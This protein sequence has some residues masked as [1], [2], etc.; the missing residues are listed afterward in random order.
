MVVAV[1]PDRLPELA[2]RCEYYGVEL[3]DIGHFTGDGVLVVRSGGAA[4]LELGTDVPAR[5][6][7]AA[8]DDGD[9]AG[10]RP[11]A[12]RHARLVDD[13]AAHAA[14]AARPPQ[15]RLQGEH[16]PSLRPRDPRCRPSCARWSAASAT[17]PPTASCS[18]SRRATDGIAIGIGVNPWYG[19][20]DPERMAYAAV[21]EA[22]RNVV[23][24]GADPD[25]VALARQLLVGRPAA[26][27]RRWASWS[28]PSTA[29][30]PPP[31]AYRAPFVSGQG[32]AQQRVH[33]RRR[34][35]PRGAADAGD[36]RRRPRARRRSLRHAG[37]A[38]GGRRRAAARRRRDPSSPGSHLDLVHGAPADARRRAR[39]RS[40]RARALPPP[41]PGDP[42]RSRAGLPRRQRGWVGGGA[43]GD[44]HRRPARHHRHRASRTT[45]S[46]RRCSPSRRV[47]PGRRGRAAS[48]STDFREILGIDT[49]S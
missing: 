16:D 8:P 43:G 36:H 4:V 47:A 41:A 39:A 7:P 13:P 22:I 12:C 48:T 21:D 32:L 15:H 25:R 46:P 44:V 19:M 11:R 14:A 35:A 23:A 9:H 24:V 38:A 42:R 30:S 37:A 1:H 27:R 45:T 40:R 2:E 20:H 6:A 10:A 17:P 26:A 3:A 18:P 28:P 33:R 31:T 5:R 29:A 34:A 49:A